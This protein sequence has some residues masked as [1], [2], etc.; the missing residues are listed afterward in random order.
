MSDVE[1]LIIFHY[2]DK[3]EFEFNRSQYKGERQKMRYLSS[4]ATCNELS[5]IALEASTWTTTSDDITLKYLLY[6]GSF[7][8]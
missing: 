4:N 6:N 1:H 8:R 7:F 5:K 2:D 3:F